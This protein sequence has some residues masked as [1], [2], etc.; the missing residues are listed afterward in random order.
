MRLLERDGQQGRGRKIALQRSPLPRPTVRLQESERKSHRS[1]NCAKQ[2]RQRP[3]QSGD[4]QEIG[5]DVPGLSK[6]GAQAEEPFIAA[7]LECFA[8]I[9]FL[10]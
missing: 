2:E 4:N 3:N 8:S 5:Q 10:Q 9:G 6:T 1:G 7:L